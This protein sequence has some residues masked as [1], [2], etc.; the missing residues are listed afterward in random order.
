VGHAADGGVAEALRALNSPSVLRLAPTITAALFLAPIGAGLIGTLLPAFGVFP[1]LGR[2]ALSLQS[3]R[4]L[5]AT[6]GL[7]TALKL[8]IGVG[9]GTTLASVILAAGFCALA[10]ERPL[11]RRVEKGLA[12][13]LATPH[14]AIAIG[15]AFLI[16]PSG[17]IARIVAAATGS[18]Q[19]PELV[20]V[21][22]SYGLSFALGLVLKETPYLVLMMIGATTQV[23]A[24]PMVAAAR[25]MGYSGPTAWLKVI[26]P[27]IYPQIRLPLYAILAY[28]LS[29]VEV[30]LILAPSAP[31]PL[32][33]LAARWFSGY[34][35]ELYLPAT[36]AATLQLLIVVFVI[37]TWHL[38]EKIAGPLGAR[39][40]AAGRRRGGAVPATLVAGWGAIATGLASIGAILSLMLWSI[41]WE[42]R[43]PEPFP[44][45]WTL[46]NW[47]RIGVVSDALYTTVLI[48]A[49]TTIVAVV[50][51]LACL[52][53]E[54]R[55]SIRPGPSL[56][57]L[58]YMPLLVPQIAFLFG[59]QVVLVRM[60]LDATFAA[61]TWAHLLFVLPY[62]FLSLADPFRALDPRYA[63]IAA[64]L[65]V[66]RHATFWRVKLPMLLKPISI[67]L[68]MGFA[69]SV[70]LYLPTLFAGAGR[71]ATLAT[72]AVTLAG[73]ADRRL[74]GVT[75]LLQASLP[76]LMYGLALALPAFLF[77]HRRGLR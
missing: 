13:L 26:F 72:E 69:V 39:W 75:A 52:E 74:V 64:G 10:F 21:R 58:L 40:V 65:G 22:D 16:A 29:V 15:F 54:H 55:R 71:I 56:L 51:A 45:S 6:P 59:I 76:L 34:E 61:V 12:P 7:A 31:P 9:V 62:V 68:A 48:G 70:G 8:T 27:Q 63:R 66:T 77:R 67:A 46:R 1:P 19:P 37:A 38:G 28:A 47:A 24:R 30:A 73:G 57:W 35:L 20:T 5:F 42:W 36:A 23:A 4:D 2:T 18:L 50:L 43:F 25:S 14:L 49:T 41:A 17:W 44:T 33:V 32:S 11:F 53:N 3:W 60:G